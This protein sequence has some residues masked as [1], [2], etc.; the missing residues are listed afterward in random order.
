[1][2]HKMMNIQEIEQLYYIIGEIKMLEDVH[3]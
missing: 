2:E 1:M 3:N